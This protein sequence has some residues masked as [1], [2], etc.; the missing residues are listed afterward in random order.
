MLWSPN[1][2][3]FSMLI[4]LLI[5]FLY[6]FSSTPL[7]LW[8]FKLYPFE[9]NYIPFGWIKTRDCF[10]IALNIS[11]SF[12]ILISQDSLHKKKKK[13]VSREENLS[14][15]IIVGI[16]VLVMRESNSISFP[17]CLISWFNCSEVMHFSIFLAVVEDIYRRRQPLPSMD[18]IYFIQ[19]S[20]EK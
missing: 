12:V 2:P 10:F 14:N 7:K 4:L 20:K 8:M 9:R 3:Q 15:R 5:T 11:S 19:P 18:A 1:Q 6:R 13:R 17:V 16:M